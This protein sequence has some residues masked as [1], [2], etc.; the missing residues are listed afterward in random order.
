MTMI[1]TVFATTMILAAIAATPAAAV[2]FVTT[3]GS[4]ASFAPT[5]G[6]VI[7][8]NGGVLPTGFSLSGTGYAQVTGGLANAYAEP[9][10]S[11]GS[12][13]VAVGTGG[14][15][16][17]QSTTGYQSASVFAG[18]IDTYNSV[19]VLSTSGAVLATFTGAD[20]TANANGDQSEPSTNRRIT[21]YAEAG[22]TI[23]GL[24]FL[25][26][27]PAFELDNVVFAVPEPSTWMMMLAG[28]G[29]LGQAMRLRRRNVRVVYA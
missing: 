22:E 6:T 19:E 14:A 28:F 16:T 25:S 24:R 1:K 20:F 11:D 17:L 26:T 8:F 7:D 12:A 27:A 4:D 13:Y 3:L 18:S 9:G 2:T 15:A 10:F 29:L 23:G 21:F 5:T